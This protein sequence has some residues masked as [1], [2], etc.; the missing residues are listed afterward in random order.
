M[1]F[2]TVSMFDCSKPPAMLKISLVTPLS[3]IVIIASAVSAACSQFLIGV[4]LLCK[5]IFLPSPKYL[6]ALG[7][8]FSTY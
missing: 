8:S 5:G 4:P 1:T 3:I 7:I 6:Q 2:L